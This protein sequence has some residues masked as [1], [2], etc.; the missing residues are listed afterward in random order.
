[1]GSNPSSAASEAEAVRK[2]E[3]GGVAVEGVARVDKGAADL[4]PIL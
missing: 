2:V 1:M 3:E 4:T